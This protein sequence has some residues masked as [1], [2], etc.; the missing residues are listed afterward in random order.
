MAPKNIDIGVVWVLKEHMKTSIIE[1]A[2][3]SC[4]KGK[5]VALNVMVSTKFVVISSNLSNITQDITCAFYWS[6]NS[7]STQDF[8]KCQ[9]FLLFN[10]IFFLFPG[11]S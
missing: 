6:R 5:H 11:S 2:L 3:D 7:I 4:S 10:T 8:W 1:T 9:G